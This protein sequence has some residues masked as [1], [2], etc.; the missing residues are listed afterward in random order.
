MN[1]HRNTYLLN[2]FRQYIYLMIIF[3]EQLDPFIHFLCAFL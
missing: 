3:I 1:N 2:F